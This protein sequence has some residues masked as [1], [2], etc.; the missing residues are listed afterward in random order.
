MNKDLTLVFSSYQSHKLLEKLI[1]KFSNKYRIIIIENSCDYEIKKKFSNLKKKIEVII[2]VKNL[3]L[4][5]SYNLG[6][7]KAKTNLVF[8]NNPD[9]EISNK[10]IIQ[11]IKCA[12]KIRKFGVIAPNY[13]NNK[14]FKNYEIFNKKKIP[15]ALFE[16]LNIIE[17]D[18]IDN[19]FIIDKR[20][21][22][23]NLFDENFFLYFETS[24]FIAKLKK[25]HKKILI[26]KKIT[27]HHYGSKSVPEEYSNLVKKTRAYHYNWS[28]FY[29]YKKNYNFI[30]GLKAIIPN[31]AKAIVKIFFGLIKFDIKAV[32]LSLLE[33]YGIISSIIGLRS[34]YRPK[35]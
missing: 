1:R 20:N 10:S 8:L 4:A 24:D 29:Y 22:N 5:K 19:S 30:Y 3:G 26:A 12:K 31:L 2:P 11:L 7:K 18:H 17:V 33:M 34:S 25:R 15:S 9:I 21:L 6:I 27:F 16:K 23:N 35:N 14:I 32:K 28:K 13:K